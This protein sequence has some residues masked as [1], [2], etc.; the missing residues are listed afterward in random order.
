M[1]R[2]DHDFMQVLLTLKCNYFYPTLLLSRTR[3]LYLENPCYQKQHLLFGS[4]I[5][6]RTDP[7][8]TKTTPK[9]KAKPVV[10]DIAEDGDEESEQKKKKQKSRPKKE[11]VGKTEPYK[12]AHGWE[13]EPKL[14]LLW[15]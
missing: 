10:D 9:R 7:M 5:S 12:G 15:K 3:R 1:C 8:A 11:D 2:Y 13:I 4:S 6:D 14:Y